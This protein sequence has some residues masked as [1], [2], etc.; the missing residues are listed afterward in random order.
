MQQTVSTAGHLPRE[1][2]AIF[3]EASSSFLLSSCEVVTDLLGE[4]RQVQDPHIEG[5]M[6]VAQG[7]AFHTLT[8]G[9]TGT[10]GRSAE[11]ETFINALYSE[12]EPAL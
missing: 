11:E 6:P 1:G 9:R 8:L 4:G 12:M 10:C 3:S 5:V 2:E 7:M